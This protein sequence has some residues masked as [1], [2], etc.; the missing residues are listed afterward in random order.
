MSEPCSH[1]VFFLARSPD[2][3]KTTMMVLSL[4][5]ME[6]QNRE[7]VSRLDGSKMISITQESLIFHEFTRETPDW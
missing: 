7:L 4:S 5:S 3:P 6:L 1:T 2:A